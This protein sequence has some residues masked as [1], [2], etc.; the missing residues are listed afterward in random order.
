MLVRLVPAYENA[1]IWII[2]QPC[3]NHYVTFIEMK[4]RITSIG[5]VSTKSLTHLPQDK[6]ATELQAMTLSVISS[7]KSG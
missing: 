3:Q 7:M 4:K 1:A 5:N 6:I 2:Y